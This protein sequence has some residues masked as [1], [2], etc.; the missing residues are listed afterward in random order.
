V[1]CA[2]AIANAWGIGTL[3]AAAGCLVAW[4]NYQGRFGY[5][6]TGRGRSIAIMIGW[7]LFFGSMFLP[8][9]H[10]FSDSAGWEV[11]WI[12]VLVAVPEYLTKREFERKD[13]VGYIFRLPWASL[14]D[15][16]NLCSAVMPLS[17]RWS[18]GRPRKYLGRILHASVPTV[19]LLPVDGFGHTFRIGYYFW[20]LALTILAST[21]P[22][23]RRTAQW[24]LVATSVVGL[25]QYLA[26][27][28]QI[29]L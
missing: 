20:V 6:Q 17:L 23:D 5:I 22:I 11:A 29:A 3:V 26:Y 19:W 2:L 16:A 27:V 9:Y 12:M 8:S 21:H 14:I 18:T 7:S 13:V 10:I 24:M 28:M 25:A 4:M 1:A 15:A